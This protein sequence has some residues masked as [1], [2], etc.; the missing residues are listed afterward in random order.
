MKFFWLDGRDLREIKAGQ[1]RQDIGSGQ[2][3]VQ[4][5]HR[6]GISIYSR[7]PSLDYGWVK[8]WKIHQIKDLNRPLLFD[9]SIRKTL[10]GKLAVDVLLYR[11]SHKKVIN[12]NTE[13]L[14]KL[15]HSITFPGKKGDRRNEA[16]WGF[17]ATI[18]LFF[19]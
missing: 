17:V 7:A 2:R 11:V 19:V 15:S 13:C 18:F 16:G 4:P 5:K 14:I 8:K 9:V 3:N 12:R 10:T 6:I 1:K